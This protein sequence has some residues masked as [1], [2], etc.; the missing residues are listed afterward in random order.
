MT[1][2]RS[3][4][5]DVSLTPWYHMIC[6]TVRGADLL[7]QGELDR[8]RWIEDRLKFL[9]EIFAID[10]ASYAVL[11]DHFQCLVRLNPSK[12][13]TWSDEKIAQK[14]AKVVPPRGKDRKTLPVNNEWITEMIADSKFISESRQRLTNAGWFMKNLKEPLARMANQADEQTGAFWQSRFKS[15]A[16]LDDEA[17]LATCVY[18]DLSS[19]ASGMAKLPEESEY[20][21]VRARIEHCRQCGRLKDVQAA[22][23]GNSAALKSIRELEKDL[24]LCPIEHRPNPLGGRDGMLEH[25]SLGTYLQ[26]VDYTSRLVR[27]G[28]ARV[29]KPVIELF[30]R[31]GTTAELWEHHIQRMF[32]GGKMTGVTYSFHREKLKKAAEYRGRQHVANLK[33]CRA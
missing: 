22:T 3:Q 14:W 32:S 25:L 19:V 8:K 21:S 4:I 13:E 28:K 1:V 30:D 6:R 2:P 9:S 12:A 27:T 24:W 17:L 15:I 23:P 7:G 31:L 11:N 5:V 26:V 29:A 20:T 18:I 16:I 10:V 33:G